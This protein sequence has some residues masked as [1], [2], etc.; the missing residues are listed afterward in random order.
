[1]E[2]LRQ[3]C[4]R[5]TD[6]YLLAQG[7]AL[8]AFG[9]PALICRFAHSGHT[10]ILTALMLMAMGVNTLLAQRAWQRLTTA[11][12]HGEADRFRASGRGLSCK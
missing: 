3:D 9:L 7:L 2:Q 10:L 5:L 12:A 6:R 4:S 8:L 11:W 1:M